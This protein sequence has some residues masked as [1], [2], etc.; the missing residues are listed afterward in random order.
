MSLTF[1][2]DLEVVVSTAY[3]VG[4][5]QGVVSCG[6]PLDVGDI[7]FTIAGSEATGLLVPFVQCVGDGSG[8]SHSLHGKSLGFSLYHVDQGSGGLKYRTNCFRITQSQHNISIS[9]FILQQC[10]I[11]V[12]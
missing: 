4:R 2:F 5:L 7:Q 3:G 9:K 8:V 6:S 10:Y 11:F 1:D 12:I